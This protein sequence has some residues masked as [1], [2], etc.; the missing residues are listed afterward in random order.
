MCNYD[1]VIFVLNQGGKIENSELFDN[2]SP[3]GKDKRTS[4]NVYVCF[5]NEP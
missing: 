3:Q 1:A 5:M 4:K 2:F